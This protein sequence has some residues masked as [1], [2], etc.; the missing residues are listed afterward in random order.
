MAMSL[1]ASVRPISTAAWRSWVDPSASALPP[2]QPTKRDVFATV[3]YARLGSSEFS[4]QGVTLGGG[5]T[6]WPTALW[7]FRFD[8][9]RYLPVAT[10]NNIPAEERSPSRYW[11]VGAGVAFR[12]R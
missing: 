12:F 2:R 3:G 4:S 5:A 8:A 10:D 7:G 9:I 6:Y 11:G 1:S